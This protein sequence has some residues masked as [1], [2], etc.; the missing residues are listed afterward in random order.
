MAQVALAYLLRLD[1]VVAIPAALSEAE[2]RENANSSSIRLTRDEIL[3]IDELS[4]SV[5]MLT[6]IFDHFAI[7]PISW[8]KASIEQ[9]SG[10]FR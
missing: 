3:D 5:G 8:T 7:R 6:W 10:T 1:C 2:V 9:L 4:V